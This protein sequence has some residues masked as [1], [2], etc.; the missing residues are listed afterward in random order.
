MIFNRFA[1]LATVILLSGCAT[2]ELDKGPDSTRFNE[3]FSKNNYELKKISEQEQKD[4]SP[5]ITSLIVNGK[6]GCNQNSSN[7]NYKEESHYLGH[8]PPKIGLSLSGGGTRAASFSIGVMKALDEIKI[9]DHLDLISSVSGGSYANYWYFSQKFYQ[10]N[11]FIKKTYPT[12]S[13]DIFKTWGDSDN[14]LD[15]P[16]KYRFQRTLEESSE[17]LGYAHKPSFTKDIRVG[18]QYGFETTFQAL[19]IPMDWIFNGL[20]DWEINITPFYYFYKDGLDR[21]YGYVPLDYTL[22]HFANA[23][24]NGLVK[25]DAEPILFG[26]MKVFLENTSNTEKLP[27]FVINTAARFGK[28]MDKDGKN[29]ERTMES[30]LF[31]F[32]PWGCHSELLHVHGSCPLKDFHLGQHFG[33]MEL[34]L[35]RIVTS[36][37]AAV[38][39]QLQFVDVSGREED[40][41]HLGGESFLEMGLDL[42]NLNLGYTLQNQNTSIWQRSFHKLLP[43]PLYL[44]HDYFLEDDATSIHLSDG[45]HSENLGILSLIQR[46]TKRIIAVDAEQDPNSIFE[47][48]KRLHQTLNRYGL[49]IKAK[50]FKKLINVHDINQLKD[51]VTEW[52]VVKKK[53]NSPLEKPILITYI[54]LAAPSKYEQ[55]NPDGKLPYSVASYLRENHDFP[56][57]T[58]ADVI[59]S[60]EQFRAYRDLGY[61]ITKKYLSTKKISG[62]NDY[63]YD[64]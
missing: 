32:T 5:K 60:P 56:H 17:I 57:E 1:L 4:I 27:Y 19:S 3:V 33:W 46:G 30:S 29:K 22:E 47:S 9:L 37:G 15:D 58:T 7:C 41:Y 13:K 24:T 23:T 59:Y 61:I 36:S 8:W 28:A 43:W 64:D 63:L 16:D 21:T 11:L 35:A 45:G 52:E 38:D 42:V 48:A 10:D 25:V 12:L 39:G 50:D 26:D 14:N 49:E 2:N 55:S 62:L 34:D 18:L 44:V 51:A 20:F 53:D 40:A 31:E 54:K 6:G